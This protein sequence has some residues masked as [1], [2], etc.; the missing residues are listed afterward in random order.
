MKEADHID[1]VLGYQRTKFQFLVGE[2]NMLLFY[3][4]LMM[5]GKTARNM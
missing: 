5:G 4:L 1:E 2:R 3:K